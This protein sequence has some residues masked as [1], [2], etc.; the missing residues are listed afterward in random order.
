M[1]R[2]QKEAAAHA[3]RILWNAT[4]AIEYAVALLTECN[5]RAEAAAISATCAGIYPDEDKPENWPED[6]TPAPT[7]PAPVAT[8]WQDEPDEEEKP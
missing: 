5:C 4:E 7:P 8:L 2:T 3:K 6:D 1:T